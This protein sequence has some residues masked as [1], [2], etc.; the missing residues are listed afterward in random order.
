MSTATPAECMPGELNGMAYGSVRPAKQIYSPIPPGE[1]SVDPPVEND[2]IVPSHADG[3]KRLFDAGFQ[4]I[5]D[6]I[7]ERLR[8]TRQSLV[9]ANHYVTS[10]K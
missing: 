9:M 6:D 10:P 7:N 4:R 3:V 5:I 1:S 8:P 2:R